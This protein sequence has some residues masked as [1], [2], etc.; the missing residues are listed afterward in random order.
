M[1]VLSP[2]KPPRRP[3]LRVSLE[4]MFKIE[5]PMLSCGLYELRC[6][7]DGGWRSVLLFPIRFN[8]SVNL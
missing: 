4:A 8:V 5:L 7:L 2:R 3:D 1:R 6:L